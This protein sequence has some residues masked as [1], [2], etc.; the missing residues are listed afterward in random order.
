MSFVKVGLGMV[1]VVIVALF[2]ISNN[3]PVQLNLLFGTFGPVPLS[4]FVIFAVLFGGVVTAAAL[5]WTV[6]SARMQTRRDARR[7]AELEQEVHGL[8]TLPMVEEPKP[9]TLTP[10]NA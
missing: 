5:G 9:D 7:I 2:A 4:V 3:E 8:R 6:A 1:V 10:R